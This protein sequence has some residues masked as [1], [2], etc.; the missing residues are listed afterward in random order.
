M[1]VQFSS[2]VRSLWSSTISFSIEEYTSRHLPSL[3]FLTDTFPINEMA[4]RNGRPIGGGRTETPSRASWRRLQMITPSRHYSRRPSSSC[5]PRCFPCQTAPAGS[6]RYT[7]SAII[8]S[9]PSRTTHRWTS[10]FPTSPSP[11]PHP[12]CTRDFPPI[13]PPPRPPRGRCS[14][15][16]TATTP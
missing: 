7:S 14:A 9:T 6:A 2:Y 12:A 16:P 3:T 10:T 15:T 5:S 4:T 11:S 8:T 13:A 1:M